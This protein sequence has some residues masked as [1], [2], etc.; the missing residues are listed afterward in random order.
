MKQHFLHFLQGIAV[1]S[2]LVSCS[3]QQQ[4][5]SQENLDGS[6]PYQELTNQLP[7]APDQIENPTGQIPH[8]TKLVPNEM[9]DE[10][11]QSEKIS[12]ADRLAFHDFKER[13]N[14][15]SEEQGTALEI[16][17]F[18]K[19]PIDQGVM[20]ISDFQNGLVLRVYVYDDTIRG[21]QV[22]E[23]AE[24]MTER[25]QLL[26]AMSQI[27]LILNPGTEPHHADYLFNEFGIGPN[28]NFENVQQRTIEYNGIQYTITPKDEEYQ[29]DAFYVD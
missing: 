29:F 15:L 1:V 17:R 24:T 26:T 20:Y 10:T 7:P 16:R 13:W 9:D 23:R 12:Q 28:A 27:Y 19:T 22:N 4:D 21:L 5:E 3:P 18:E 11:D 8:Q 2:L 25:F 14:S 6:D